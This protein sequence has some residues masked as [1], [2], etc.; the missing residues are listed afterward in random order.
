MLLKI[1]SIGN[2]NIF[3]LTP[4]VKLK[5]KCLLESIT[6]FRSRNDL[7]YTPLPKI[8]EAETKLE[9]RQDLFPSRR[10]RSNFSKSQPSFN[11]ATIF[12]PSPL[13]KRFSISPLNHKLAEA[14]SFTT[15]E[16]PLSTHSAVFQRL[17]TLRSIT[18]NGQRFQSLFPPLP[19]QA[20]YILN[21]SCRR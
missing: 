21:C 15:S 12:L 18:I 1:S 11:H 2:K 14:S 20:L 10:L 16:Q 6:K 8:F 5:S 17:R 9:P 13:P 7:F 4:P 3:H 19:I